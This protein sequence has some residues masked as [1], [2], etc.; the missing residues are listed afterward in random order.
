ML[1]ILALLLDFPLSIKVV[2]NQDVRIT[3]EEFTLTGGRVA[4]DLCGN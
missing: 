1:P 3:R 2:K 4:S